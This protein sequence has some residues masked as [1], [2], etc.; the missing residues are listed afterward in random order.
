M[1]R[2]TCQV[3]AAVLAVADELAAQSFP[4]LNGVL[5]EVTLGQPVSPPA[6]FVSVARPESHNVAWRTTGGM[7]ESFTVRI[8]VQSEAS[9]MSARDAWSDVAALTAVVERMLRGSD[10][11]PM[12]FLRTSLDVDVLVD[13]TAVMS[14][15]ARV[16]PTESGWGGQALID[17]PVTCRI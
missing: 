1:Q 4:T 15:D 16:Y 3:F 6:R 11:Q 7:T 17:I 10:G 2:L 12:A 5:C 14:I 9:W 8:V 13:T